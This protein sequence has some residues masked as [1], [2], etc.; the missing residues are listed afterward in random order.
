M[1]RKKE[2]VDVCGVPLVSH[3]LVDFPWDHQMDLDMS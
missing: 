1:V 2:R 3:Y